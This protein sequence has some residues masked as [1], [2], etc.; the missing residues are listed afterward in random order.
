MYNE[1]ANGGGNYI[2]FDAMNGLYVQVYVLFEWFILLAVAVTVN[3]SAKYNV[4]NMWY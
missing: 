4:L 1:P 2:G 3:G